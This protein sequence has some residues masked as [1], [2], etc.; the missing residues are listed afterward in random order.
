MVYNTNLESQVSQRILANGKNIY[1]IE[2]K[3]PKIL[4][5]NQCVYKNDFVEKDFF[6]D[7]IVNGL[8][9]ITAPQMASDL[10]DSVAKLPESILSKYEIIFQNKTD[11]TLADKVNN[12]CIKTDVKNLADINKI[13]AAQTILQQKDLE[14]AAK[15]NILKGKKLCADV[16]F[17][18]QIIFK[19]ASN[20]EAGL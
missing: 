7:Y 3:V 16:R 1:K 17:K 20:K 15:K 2:T 5:N 19:V 9:N 11:I 13:A 4:I 18:E 12:F 14:F 10:A 8:Y 6:K